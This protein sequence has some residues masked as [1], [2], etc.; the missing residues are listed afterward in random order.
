MNKKLKDVRLSKGLS[1]SQLAEEAELNVRTLQHYEQGTKNFDNAKIGTILK[2]AI[3]LDCKIEDI[4][5]NPDY[6]KLI[7]HY[8][9]YNLR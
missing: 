4:I 5:Q 2:V 8:N 6:L 1:Q 3:A 7:E 9:T